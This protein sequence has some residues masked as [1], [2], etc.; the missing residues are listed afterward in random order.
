MRG[1]I[2]F[3]FFKKKAYVLYIDGCRTKWVWGCSGCTDKTVEDQ[4]KIKTDTKTATSKI[5]NNLLNNL[6]WFS[7]LWRLFSMF[8][9]Y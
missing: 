6:T 4:Y 7:E 9:W 5:R 8:D 3:L 1:K 2:C